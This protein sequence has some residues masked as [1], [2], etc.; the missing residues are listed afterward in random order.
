MPRTA[1]F[2]S[3]SMGGAAR[4]T[5][6]PTV[7]RQDPGKTA[8]AAP[9][10]RG[11]SCRRCTRNWGFFACNSSRVLELNIC[12]PDDADR[13]RRAFQAHLELEDYLEALIRKP[14][15]RARHHWNRPRLGGNSCQPPA[16]TQLVQTMHLF[17]PVW[18]TEVGDENG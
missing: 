15:A 1:P 2:T 10:N 8:P 16:R 12:R 4:G 18:V 14:G 6:G 13:P 17:S 5:H 7:A 9:R 11:R 3:I